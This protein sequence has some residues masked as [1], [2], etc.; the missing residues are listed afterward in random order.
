MCSL[1]YHLPEEKSSVAL[2][3]T[4]FEMKYEVFGNKSYQFWWRHV[5]HERLNHNGE[6]ISV[7][8]HARFDH[9]DGSGLDFLG[10]LVQL[11]SKRLSQAAVAQRPLEMNEFLL[12]RFW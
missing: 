5:N 12:I 2:K 7:V 6:V 4:I 3:L 11:C 8:K 9:L 1:G 10:N